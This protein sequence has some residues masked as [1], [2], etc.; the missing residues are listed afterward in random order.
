MNI[1]PSAIHDGQRGRR[2][3]PIPVGI[4]LPLPYGELTPL[5]YLK[6]CRA[7]I[8]S[9]F[10]SFWVG[11]HLLLPQSS[12]SVYP[13]TRDGHRPFDAQAPWLDPLLLATWLAAQ[14]PDVQFGTSV[15]I[16]TLRHPVLLAKQLASMSWLTRRPIA[17]GVGTGWLRDEYD[18]VGQQF[19]HRATRA[20]SDILQI[21]E[22][23]TRGAR[24]YT[25]R[26][27]NDEPVEKEFT[28]KPVAQAPIEF[29]WGGFSPVALRLTAA[30]CDGWLPAKQSLE[31]LRGQL[32][33]LKLACDD[34]HR[35]YRELRLVAKPGP[36]PDP[37]HG[38]VDKDNLAGYAELGFDEVILELPLNTGTVPDAIRVIER[39]ATRTWL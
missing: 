14:F 31:S 33:S 13:H 12:S 15:M 8:K 21:R 25:V 29:L 3:P 2:G 7:A 30:V 28:M 6:I 38:R 35:D 20:R 36:G 27:G 10:S 18:V 17:L 26:D 24:K 1:K 39:V 22:L 16:M 37:E 4:R 19:E 32:A 23:V 34:V 11:D 5:D 9:G